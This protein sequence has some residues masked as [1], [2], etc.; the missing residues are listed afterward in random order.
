MEFLILGP[1]EVRNGEQTVR[2]GAAKQRALLGV[3]LLHANE[4]VST[5]RLVDE[6]WGE[7]P[8]A[9]A[10]KLVQGYVHA[11]RKQ[12]GDGVVE[13]QAPGYRLRV[14]PPSLDLLEFERLT[15][16]ARSAPVAYGIELRR[17]ALALWRGPALADVVL[18][19]PERYNVG[20]L[21]EL[22]LATQ[23]ERIDAEVQLGRHAQVVA[24][25][26]ALVAEHPYQERAAALL[27]LALY[28]SGRQAEALEVYRTVRGRLSDELGLQPGQELRDL[29]AAILRQDDAL[30]T[31]VAEREPAAADAAQVE[32]EL[33]S[34]PTPRRRRRLAL[35]GTLALLAVAAIALAALLLRQEPAPILAEPNSVAVIDVDTNRVKKVIS[36]GNMPG[37]VAAGAGLVW[38]GNLDDPSLTRIDPATE[39]GHPPIR[40]EATPDAV[41]VGGGAVWVVNGLLGTLE[42]VDPDSEIAS[43]PIELGPRSGRFP[44][45]GADFGEGAVWAAFGN[46]TLARVDSANPDRVAS[47]SVTAAGPTALVFAFGYVWVASDARKVETFN[48][49]TW[50]EGPVSDPTVCRSPSGIAAGAGEIWVACRDDNVVQQIPDELTSPSSTPIPVG[51]G[52]TAVAFGADAVWVANRSDGT[53]SRIDPETHDVVSIEVGNAPAGIAYWDGRIWVSVQEPPLTP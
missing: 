28:R 13:T 48:P 32:P 20:R 23:I 35:G 22:R 12:L 50:D 37:P 39:D 30:A 14:G 15:E 5:S 11:L 36:V 7:R 52:P 46:A 34:A 1:L 40:L 6:L 19:G 49:D 16:E 3:L 47:S 9:T 51:E 41:A 53:V 8:P 2:L 25:L 38:V 18:E 43:D 10:E 17:R 45:A 42:R 44:S 4:T 31:P 33:P 27:M 24:E 21:G 26:E 29:E